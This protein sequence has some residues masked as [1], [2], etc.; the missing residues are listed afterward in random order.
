MAVAA[1]GSGCVTLATPGPSTAEV[2]VT[3]SASDTEF[4]PEVLAAPA[5]TAIAVSF[6]ND[7]SEPHTL[8]FL[9]PISINHGAVVEPGDSQTLLFNT[10]AAGDYAFVCN[11][12]E[13]MTGILRV[14]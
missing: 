1:V 6:R 13:G 10:P 3:M 2:V 4:L 7:S 9:E 14:K 12:H 8:I 5:Q 11:V